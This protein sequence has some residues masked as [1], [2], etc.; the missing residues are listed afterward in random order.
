MEP[1]IELQLDLRLGAVKGVLS[2]RELS[3]TVAPQRKTIL[4]IIK[5]SAR[6]YN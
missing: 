3:C 1:Y 2:L 5:C 6:L 4:F